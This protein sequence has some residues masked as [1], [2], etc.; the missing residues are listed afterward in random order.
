MGSRLGRPAPHHL[1]RVP[2]EPAARFSRSGF[3]RSG[4]A[5]RERR[6]WYSHIQARAA[7]RLGHQ[8]AAGSPSGGS[9][10][11]ASP[12]PRQLPGP[13][14]GDEAA[15][16]GAPRSVSPPAG[17][18]PLAAAHRHPAPFGGAGA[19][20][21]SRGRPAEKGKEGKRRRRAGPISAPRRGPAQRRLP[22]PLLPPP[23][24]PGRRGS[25]G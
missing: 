14:A 15:V 17:Q 2:A 20:A 4:A 8:P 11:A 18:T 6:G 5:P 3:S 7:A 1:R 22:A 23:Q 13:P 16:P 12:D 21:G 24:L 10:P 9:G 19:G 25:E